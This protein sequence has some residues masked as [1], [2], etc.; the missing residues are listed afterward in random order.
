MEEVFD[1]ETFRRRRFRTFRGSGVKSPLVVSEAKKNSHKNS[2]KRLHEYDREKTI[3]TL[4]NSEN[5]KTYFF[6]I[7]SLNT[8]IKMKIPLLRNNFELLFFKRCALMS[9]TLR[10]AQSPR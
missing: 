9:Y 10:F 7:W 6:K 5:A 2:I 4:A 1:R 3:M 8:E